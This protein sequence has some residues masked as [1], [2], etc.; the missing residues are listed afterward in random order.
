V[1]LSLQQFLDSLSN[2]NTKK[3]YHLG[4]VKFCQW[5]GKSPRE[6]LELRKDDLTQRP[7]EDLIVYR[8]RAARFERAIEQ[9]HSALLEQ[10]YSMNS[11]RGMTI[12]IRQLFRYYQMPV[13]MRPGSKVTKTVKTSKSFPLRIEHV[14]RL[15]EV[16]D[17]RERVILSLATDL[18][19]RI[20]DFIGI[21]KNE[22]PS[23][24]Q[25]PPI[26]FDVMTGKEDVIAH[27]FLS[28]ETV[29][30][31]KIYLLTLQK[32]GNLYL[33]PSN[34]NRPI[35]DVWLN[36]L[37]QKLAEKAHI[38]LNGKRLTF[39]CFR[40]MFL[41]AAID[42]GI[43]LTAGKKLCGKTIPHSDDTYLTT[44]KLR[45]KF[46][47]L[48]KLLTIRS[49]PEPDAEEQITRLETALEQLQKEHVTN[50]TAAYVMTKRVVELE[51]KLE[52]ALKITE[53]L[54]PLTEFMRSFKSRKE[55]HSFLDLFRHASILRFP[56]HK[57]RLV[58]EKLEGSDEKW[59]MISEIFHEV[60]ENM[61]EHTLDIVL[62]QLEQEDH[63]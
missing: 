49:I 37:L 12:G 39:H 18:G 42:S 46:L 3:G 35:S 34:G 5:F 51:T 29:D 38:P 28:R 2:T 36:R 20:S 55:L 31:L 25:E 19:L 44:V 1:E 63:K 57:L 11:S 62:K 52:A 15:F 54:E 7:R 32:K 60:W 22:L 21:Q 6:V 47:Q 40:K 23:L 13:R 61:T 53:Q 30:L 8:N 48:K 24:T 45:D 59:V 50:Q 33:F 4:I 56:E 27:G 43:G 10:G 58:L 26:Q 41:S 14:R 17:L 9:Y 16:A